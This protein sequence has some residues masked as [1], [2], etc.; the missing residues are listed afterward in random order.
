MSW[1]LPV[2]VVVPLLA[3]AVNAALDHISPRWLHSA[4]TL[5]GV[6][7]ALG[8]SCVILADS[9]S[10]ETLH[11][12]GGWAPRS[13][14]ALGVAFASDPIGA[15]MA[16]IACALTFVA[17]VY[18]LTF[19]DSEK[20]NYDVLMAAACGGVCGFALSADLFN[21]FV[22]LELLGVAGYALTGFDIR[23]LSALQGA[24][25]FAV[26]NSVGSYLLVIGIALVYARTGALNL[27]QIG[28][29]LAGQQPNGVVVVSMTLIFVGLLCKAAVV[30]FHFWLADAYAVAPAPVC[31][32]LA[33]VLT[34]VGVFGVGRVWFTVFD[35]S[36][37]THQRIVGDTLLWVGIVTA[38]LGGVMALRQHHLKRLLA[39]SVIC[40][41]GIIMCGVALLS[42]KGVAGAAAL[43]LSHGLATGALF[44]TA[45]MLAVR[46]PARWLAGLWFAGVVALIGPPYIGVFLGHS[47]IDDAAAEIGRHWVQPLLWLAGTLGGAALLRGG[48]TTFLGLGE[49]HEEVGE[50]ERREANVPL[51]AGCAGVLTVAGFAISFLPGLGQRLHYGADRF[52]A[53]AEYANRVLHS[54]PVKHTPHLPVTV[55]HSTGETFA[56]S[57]AST[58]LAVLLAFVAVYRP[59]MRIRQ[60]LEPAADGLEQLHTGV[61]GDY[62]MWIVVGTAVLG[63]LWALTLR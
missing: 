44:L 52:R 13:G 41:I 7:T 31:L 54:I 60:L 47:L 46:P 38:L 33:G 8:F 4:V 50:E 27:A 58:V 55:L 3:G 59:R 25:N 49:R 51:L 22:W 39:Y 1:L 30:P 18:S 62:V 10:H 12:F 48:M 19:I 37:G 17:L 11:W 57:C 43:V 23:R 20:R 35:A 28:R 21:L 29:T 5:G 42:S 63:G 36:F 40:H 16:V 26:V 6:A 34:D 56:Y 32:V 9:M 15:G 14:V 53:R 61:I 2:P 45:G 24:L